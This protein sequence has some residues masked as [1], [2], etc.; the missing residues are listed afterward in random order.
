MLQGFRNFILRGNVVDLAVAVIMGAAFGAVVDSMVKDVITPLVGAL[1][2][3]PDFSALRLGPIQ[4]GQFINAVVAFVLKAAV[5]Y[6][7]IVLPMRRVLGLLNQ[8]ALDPP[9]SAEVK[10]LREIRDLLQQQKDQK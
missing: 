1:G 2:G 3:A 9:I 10:L 7:V 6:F 4:I 8:E 5:V